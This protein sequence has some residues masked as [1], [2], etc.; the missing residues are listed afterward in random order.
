MADPYR[1]LEDLGAAETQGW[2]ESQES[3]L[4]SYL[5]RERVAAPER[6]IEALGQTG[7]STSVPT[8]AGGRYFYTVREPEQRLAVIFAR[9]GLENDGVTVLDP[10]VLLGENQRLGGF[11]L[12]PAGRYLVYRVVENG[13]R[14]GD[15]KILDVKTGRT[16]GE[17]IDGVAAATTVWTPDEGGFYY[18]DYGHTKGLTSGD[19]EAAARV[20]FH[21]VGADSAEDAVVFAQP[22]PRRG[23]RTNTETPSALFSL[24]RS[25]DGRFLVLAVYEGKADANRLFYADLVA[26]SLEFVEL[27]DDGEHA[28]QFLGSR[29]DR[30]FLYTN[31]GAP[32]GRIVA[33]DRR[34]APSTGDPGEGRWTEVVAESDE[35]LA[36]G[37]SV[38]GNAMSM[39]GDRLVLLYR[40]ANLAVLR[41]HRT[42]GRLERE[43]PLQAGWIGSGLVGDDAVPGE[44][45]FSFNGF[46]EPS[47]VY[48]LDLETGQRRPFVRRE[49]PIDPADY[50]L[51]HVFYPSKD[52]TRVPL[53]VA[54]KRGVRRDGESPVFM[55]GYG[56][57]GW[58]A[59]PWYQ[60]HILAWL[61]MGG[62][63]AMP[64]IRGGGEYGDAWRDAGIRLNRQNAVDDYV[65]AAEWLVA[66]RYTSTG[67]V[68]ANG[69][70][71]S[72]SLAA[73]AVQQR[74]EL[75]GAALIGIPSL[76]M[77]RY[78]HFTAIPGW[79][80]GYGSAD[81]P[82]E[83]KVLHGYSPY[84][85][86]VEREDRCTP[87]T[88]VT[89]GEKDEV[90]PPLHGYKF[91]A[92]LQHQRRTA[93]RCGAPALLKIVRGAGHAF[94]A[95]PE[96][97][98][99]T[100]AEE[101]SFLAQVLGMEQNAPPSRIYRQRMA[102]RLK[103][104]RCTKAS[105]SWVGRCS[106]WSSWCCCP[107]SST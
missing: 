36:G 50:L 20:R 86:A 37:S 71:A 33:V 55:Y 90:T 78:H 61:E 7:A 88:L 96:Q 77:L 72:G 27:S 82:E 58:V 8:F 21:L 104:T 34:S 42:N 100:Y 70:S 87:P 41:V 48:R 57:G 98:R 19:S 12:S 85:H 24:A 25:G 39:I 101:L 29:G 75:F 74:P 46:V 11:S 60:P 107:R 54:R 89:V 66:E 13:T 26:E 92:A 102:E 76:D 23:A 22:S 91:V 45:W 18:V 35:V 64:G 106:A 62:I 15:L 56:F 68:I 9:R 40:R 51:E 93:E 81:D 14:W 5:D 43:I 83:F 73:A 99:H 2:M 65:A 80:R 16:L 3:L 32:N 63:F 17:T 79:T 44:V 31:H 53:F 69:W 103:V 6:R 67:K 10:N 4:G 94:G 49:L 84:H 28:Y 105:S 59:V 95:T 47:T 97:S 30:F 52:G 38:G 1:W